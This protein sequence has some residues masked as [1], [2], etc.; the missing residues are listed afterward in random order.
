MKALGKRYI[1]ELSEESLKLEETLPLTY[2]GVSRTFFEIRSYHRT[3]LHSWDPDKT[4]EPLSRH[5]T[6]TISFE[7]RPFKILKA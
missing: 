7:V 1:L 4:V 6:T 3:L 5:Y 2:R